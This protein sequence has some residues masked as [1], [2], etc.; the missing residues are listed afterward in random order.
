VQPGGKIVVLSVIQHLGV[1]AELEIQRDQSGGNFSSS[2]AWILE[3]AGMSEVDQLQVIR[4]S[5][6]EKTHRPVLLLHQ[7]IR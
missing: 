3:T 4:F 7:N 1:I 6:V 5:S 2:F